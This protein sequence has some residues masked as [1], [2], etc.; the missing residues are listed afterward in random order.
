[1][2]R[3]LKFNGLW[4]PNDK[5][6]LEKLVKITPNEE[7][8]LFEVVPHAG[9]YYSSS[10]IKLFFNSLDSK[11]NK[12]I[13]LSPSHYYSLEDNL[14]V[15]GNFEYYE[16][17]FKNIKGFSLSIFNQDYERVTVEEHAI[18][19]ILP[20]IAQIKN[21]SLCTAHVNKFTDINIANEYAHKI[22]STIDD[23]TAV[24]ASSDF[25]HYG[26]RFNFTPYGTLI[27]E[28]IVNK[29]SLHDREVANQFLKGNT[30]ETYLKLNNKEKSTI[31]G[32]APILIVSE[33]A[34]INKM[35]GKILA[36]SNSNTPPFYEK[37][38]VSY[39]TLAWRK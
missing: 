28:D 24:I 18:E 39:L 22:L 33:M 27:N 36:Q 20:F 21:I 7:K 2:I 8:N 12:I 23:R 9:L 16:S 35:K 32:L 6:E 13:L 29:V 10:L 1:M 3:K 11:V 38:F 14:I 31:C 4:Y 25:T 26:N 19:M 5:E 30:S 37:N 17:K 34:R 15:S